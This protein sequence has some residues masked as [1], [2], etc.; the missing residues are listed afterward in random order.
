MKNSPEYTKLYSRYSN[1]IT[2]GVTVTC[3]TFKKGEMGF[4]ESDCHYPNG[5]VGKVVGVMPDNVGYFVVQSDNNGYFVPF[6]AITSIT[7][8]RGR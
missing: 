1:N 3:R 6:F 8:A 5:L 4:N 7:S 2:T